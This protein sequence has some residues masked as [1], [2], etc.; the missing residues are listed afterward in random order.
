MITECAFCGEKATKLCDYLITRNEDDAGCCDVT[1]DTPLCSKCAKSDGAILY[2]CCIGKPSNSFTDTRDYCPTHTDLD[3]I[4]IKPV[5][6]SEHNT[7]IENWRKSHAVEIARYN[8]VNSRVTTMPPE[9]EG[10][11]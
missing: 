4:P 5:F 11:Q 2:G 7:K 9:S 3:K 1:C 10:V 8:M 6:I